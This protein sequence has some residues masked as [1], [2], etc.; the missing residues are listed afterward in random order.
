S[1]YGST[2]ALI[3]EEEQLERGTRAIEMLLRGSEHST[4]FHLLARLRKEAAAAEA[5][6]PIED[7]PDAE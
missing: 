2:V 6:S 5:E 1:V 4:V 7:L 3:G